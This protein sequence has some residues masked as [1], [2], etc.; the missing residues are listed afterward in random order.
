VLADDVEEVDAAS[1]RGLDL[2]RRGHVLS[3][4]HPR[5]CG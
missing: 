1:G 2:L 5:L 4:P 3:V